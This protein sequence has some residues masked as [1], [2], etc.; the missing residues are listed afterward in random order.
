M[1]NILVDV[2][3]NQNLRGFHVLAA[4]YL[5]ADQLQSARLYRLGGD[6][7]NERTAVHSFSFDT[8]LR[9]RGVWRLLLA[10]HRFDL[11]LS[12]ANQMPRDNASLAAQR[13][14]RRCILALMFN[15]DPSG[16]PENGL[17]L[18]GHSTKALA[19]SL[20]AGLKVN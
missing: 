1:T 3:E 13:T 10:D 19:D 9:F 4:L 17:L 8:G 18:N 2:R 6:D 7:S 16:F 11:Y 14:S 5:I 20:L 12:A 15:D